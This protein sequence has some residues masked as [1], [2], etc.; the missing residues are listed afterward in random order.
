MEKRLSYQRQ[1]LRSAV[2]RL[3]PVLESIHLLQSSAPPARNP[4][5]MDTL[6]TEPERLTDTQQR[7]LWQQRAK[8]RDATCQAGTLQ[9]L[10]NAMKALV[11]NRLKAPT[12]PTLAILT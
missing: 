9:A 11:L 3:R 1:R 10:D 2:S 12:P 6:G 5:K 8:E 7:R 4:W